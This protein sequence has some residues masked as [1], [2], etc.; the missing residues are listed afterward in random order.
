MAEAAI[1]PARA[2]APIKGILILIAGTAIFSVQDVLIR[3]LSGGYAA[4]EIV[5]VRC[6]FALL[7]VVPFALFTGGA[8]R[9][10]TNRLRLH[11]TRSFAGFLAYTF[12]YMAIAAIPLAD[13][14]A[15][16]FSAPLIVTALSTVFLGESVGKH[17]WM[18]VIVGFA[19]VILMIRPGVGSFD[20]AALL[21]LVAA[22]C[23]GA[24]ILMT[25]RLGGSEHPTSML[26]FTTLSFLVFSTVIG[27]VIGDGAYNNDSHASAAFLLR[28]WT[29]PETADL[30][31]MAACG[32][33]FSVGVYCLSTAYSI[34]PPGTVTPFEYTAII[35]AVVWGYAIWDEAPDAMT[36]AGMA[37]VV[38]SGLY[39]VHRENVRNR[40]VVGDHAMRPR[41][42]G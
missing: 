18:A 31:K 41:A 13:A 25:R 9:F 38:A 14:V 24:M 4:H 33:I 35:W 42:G 21:A 8:A 37:V 15:I 36:L 23:Y 28:A 19:G 7:L 27:L 1:S 10:K 11:V 16:T 6:F 5:F 30:A 22:L 26:I 3:L 12:Y 34:A 17:R 29:W 40:T 39:V 32:L 20:P 2:D